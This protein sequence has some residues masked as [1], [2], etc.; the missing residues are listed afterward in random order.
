M[1]SRYRGELIR[2]GFPVPTE[3]QYTIRCRWRPPKDHWNLKGSHWRE[4]TVIMDHDGRPQD[5]ANDACLYLIGQNRGK[6]VAV[7][8]N[9]PRN[10]RHALQHGT[11]DWSWYDGV[12]TWDGDVISAGSRSGD[13]AAV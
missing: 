13:P 6:V 3:T 11:F 8:V 7:E 2:L 4:M 5:A 12:V 9:G 1:N 10:Q